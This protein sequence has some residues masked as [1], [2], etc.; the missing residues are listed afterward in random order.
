M[1]S[2]GPTLKTTADVSAFL[3]KCTREAYTGKLEMT[4]AKGL[5]YLCTVL[6]KSLETSDLEARIAVLEK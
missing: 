3:A 5:A 6:L 2:R 4:K 1:A